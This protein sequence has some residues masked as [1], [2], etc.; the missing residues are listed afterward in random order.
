MLSVGVFMVV[1]GKSGGSVVELTQAL[2]GDVST[3][4]SE[5]KI[6]EDK[7]KKYEAVLELIEKRRDYWAMN[8]ELPP[9]DSI[10]IYGAYATLYGTLCG[11]ARDLEIGIKKHE[12]P[13]AAKEVYSILHNVTEL[14]PKLER[15]HEMKRAPATLIGEIFDASRDLRKQAITRQYIQAGEIPNRIELIK[16][17]REEVDLQMS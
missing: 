9:I 14:I 10:K 15:V 4:I 17:L 2:F 12:N 8:Q 16:Q 5:K 3:F 13:K 6:D 11:I 7:V 1:A